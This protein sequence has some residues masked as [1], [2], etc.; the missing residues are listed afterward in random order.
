MEIRLARAGGACLIATLA[1]VSSTAWAAQGLE[2]QG[3]LTLAQALDA[4][5]SANPELAASRYE[6]T[7]AQAR[8]VQANKKLN[9]EISIE[10]ENFAGGGPYQGVDSLETTLAFSQVVELGGKRD[11]RRSI[12]EI[13]SEA[14]SMELR[15][16]QLDLLADVTRKYIDV[17][18]AQEKVGFATE[19]TSLAEKTQQAIA[20]RVKSGRSPVAEESRAQIDLTRAQIE[21]RQADIALETARSALALSWGR[22]DAQFSRATAD[23]FKFEPIDSFESL[24]TKIERT[25][26]ILRFASEARM[27]D[28]E[29]RLA[30]VQT[31]PN[32]AFSVGVR[33]F[34]ESS[35]A[36]L[37]A[38]FS[39]PLA[40]YD[41]NQGAITEARARRAQ[42]DANREAS[43]ARTLGTL[44]ALYREA[45]AAK[46]RAIAL[47]DRAIPQAREALSQT[48]AGYERG[49]FS[50]L[51]LQTAQ[52]DLLAVSEAAIE[53]AADYHRLLAEIERLTSEPLTTQNLE[54]PLP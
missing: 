2:P 47:R 49:R 21:Q 39:M 40:I 26:D 13:D 42:V 16:R 22:I 36:A 51:E 8:V 46:D 14:V 19:H 53:A 48:R 29:L 20:A 41:R 32:V 34:E 24:S 17:V 15:A 38:G 6:L 10:L 25:P 12:A 35:D 31:R 45:Y 44:F 33:R 7:A 18:A 52:Q 28:A 11:L 4:A 23:L 54:A 27:R 5:L 3:P 1:V 30:R 50:F 9:P 43:K 37:V